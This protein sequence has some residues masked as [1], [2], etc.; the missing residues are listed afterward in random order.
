MAT[1]GKTVFTQGVISEQMRAQRI[2]MLQAARIAC[3]RHL[4][5]G[6]SIVIADATGKPL[7]LSGDSL[8]A[9]IAQLDA[10]LA[11]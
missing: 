9:R 5:L 4:R 1:T 2:G 11:E 7:E 10:A 6:Q 8:A 3:E